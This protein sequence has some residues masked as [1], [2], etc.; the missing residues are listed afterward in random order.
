MIA[1]RTAIL[2]VALVGC[3]KRNFNDT[4]VDA[5]IVTCP[6]TY[7]AVAGA[8]NL[9]FGPRTTTPRSWVAAQMACLNEGTVLAAPT[10]RYEALALVDLANVSALWIG[11]S[12]I[13]SADVW[14]TVYGAPATYLPWNPTNNEPDGDGECVY[15]TADGQFFDRVCADQLGGICECR[16]E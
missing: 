14:T 7:T 13:D 5:P 4:E 2:L 9:K 10:S 16:G 15:M 3:G 6:S 12:R 1:A 11:V 8:G